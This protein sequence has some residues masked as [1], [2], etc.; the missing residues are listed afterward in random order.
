MI[1]YVGSERLIESDLYTQ[2][3]LKECLD[4]LNNK[5]TS[6]ALDTETQG[7]FDHKNKIIMLQ[8]SNGVDAFVIDVRVIDILPLKEVLENKLCILQNA[9]FD[10][11]FLK[12]HGIELKN[13]ADTFLNEC[14]LTNGIENRKLGLDAIAFKYCDVVLDKT[15]RNDFSKLIDKPFTDKQII[16]GVSDVLC[17][18]EIYEKQTIELIKWNLLNVAQ[19]EYETCLTLA[20]MEYT[21]MYI[22]TDKWKNLASKAQN[23]TEKLSNEIDEMVFNN[24]KLSKFIKKYSQLDLFGKVERV[25]DIKYSSPLQCLKMFKQLGLDIPSTNAK[26]LIKYQNSEPLVKKFLDYKEE[27]KLFTTYG[28]EF[29]NFINPHTNKIHTDFFQILNTHRISSSKPNM[30]QIPA[31]KDYLACFEA[32]KG[33]KIVGCDFSAQELRLITELSQDPLWVKTFNEGGD[34]HSIIASKVFNIPEDKVKDNFEY[35]YVG[36]VKVFLRGKPPRHIAK[37]IN[38]MLAL[39]K[40]NYI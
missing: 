11:K 3:T 14:I 33:F 17:L 21:G 16:Y 18:H 30:Q 34:I 40:K 36:K 38:F 5:C 22:N 32:P 26:D 12:L 23:N 29:L 20:D 24:P 7:Y 39:I 6:I 8:L 31:D 4:F 25:I 15:V 28:Y 2:S 9:K 19:L 10:Y 13:I 35:L 1:Y 37:V 27:E